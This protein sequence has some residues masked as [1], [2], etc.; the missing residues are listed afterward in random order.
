MISD[1]KKLNIPFKTTNKKNGTNIGLFHKNDNY[2]H[3]IS[4]FEVLVVS[5]FTNKRIFVCE[6]INA[7]HVRNYN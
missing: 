5:I 2:I 3:K 6:S 4:S 7:W 1:F